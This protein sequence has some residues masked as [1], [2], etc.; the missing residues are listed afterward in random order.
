MH[1]DG[2]FLYPGT[3]ALEETGKGSAKG[4]K[5]NIPMPPGA[6]DSLFFKAWAQVE[7]FVEKGSP[8]FILLQAG[9]DS[10]AGDPIT[11][12]GY[13]SAAHRHAATRLCELAKIHCD[14]RLLALGGGGYNLENLAEGWCSVVE[15]M[16]EAG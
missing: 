12:L 4:T 14:G 6:G 15:A 1:E 7:R 13:S 3:G 16:L 8:Q 2:R 10:L 9:A 5:L 11:H